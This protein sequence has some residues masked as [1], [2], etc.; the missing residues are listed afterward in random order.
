[1]EREVIV[2]KTTELAKTSTTEEVSPKTQTDKVIEYIK[3][4]PRATPSRLQH[5]LEVREGIKLS[6]QKLGAMRKNVKG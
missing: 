2:Q 3:K 5:E 4:Y 6:I 1:M